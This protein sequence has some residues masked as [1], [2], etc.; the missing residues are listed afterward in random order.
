MNYLCSID[1]FEVFTSE[2][3]KIQVKLD[4]SDGLIPIVSN[5]DTLEEVEV[6]IFNLSQNNTLVNKNRC[7]FIKNLLKLD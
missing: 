6:A 5:L 7:H 2:N 3:N 4:T 1:G